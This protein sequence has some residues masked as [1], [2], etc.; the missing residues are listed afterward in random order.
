MKYQTVDGEW[1]SNPENK[2][3]FDASHPGSDVALDFFLAVFFWERPQ[4]PRSDGH[5]EMV[6]FR[7]LMADI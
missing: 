3:T 5:Q 7:T 1:L 4:A 2:R 6:T